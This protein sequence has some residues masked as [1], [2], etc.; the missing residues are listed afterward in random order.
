MS[1]VSSHDGSEKD[2]FLHRMPD[3][4]PHRYSSMRKT[5]LLDTFDAVRH[6]EVG[7]SLDATLTSVIIYMSI[8]FA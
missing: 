7:K 4:F 1:S 2:V 6:R 3:G 8:F 5:D